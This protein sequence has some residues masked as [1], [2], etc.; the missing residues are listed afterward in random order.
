MAFGNNL[1][2]KT[3]TGKIYHSCTLEG[4]DELINQYEIGQT[5][6]CSTEHSTQL[7]GRECV[8]IFK[9]ASRSGLHCPVDADSGQNNGYDEFRF[10]FENVF[11][12][13]EEIKM[14]ESAYERLMLDENYSDQEYLDDNWE[15]LENL[16]CQIGRISDIADDNI[17]WNI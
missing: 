9:A 13:I 16:G 5:V 10:C 6:N 3:I 15:W 1:I 4:M 14:S 2:K 11:D 12:E 17:F 7:F 8:I